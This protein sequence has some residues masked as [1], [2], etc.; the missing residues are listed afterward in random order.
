MYTKDGTRETV[1]L[2]PHWINNI[3]LT[4]RDISPSIS[5]LYSCRQPL[6]VDFGDSHRYSQLVGSSPKK[7][8]S[9]QNSTDLNTNCWTIVWGL[10]RIS[11]LVGWS[12][13]NRRLSSLETVLYTNN[14]ILR[15]KSPLNN[16]LLSIDHMFNKYLCYF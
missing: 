16:P 11:V 10:F 4:C 6:V 7:S 9:V 1:W 14:S 5:L 15:C 13:K 2:T 3:P 12:D 8:G